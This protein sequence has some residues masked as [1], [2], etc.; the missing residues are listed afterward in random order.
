MPSFHPEILRRI[1]FSAHDV[2]TLRQLGEYRGKQE[3]F[4]RQRP[5]VLETLR[6]AAVVESTESSN[7]LEGIE[8]PK[9]STPSST[10]ST[11][12]AAPTR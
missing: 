11:P 5:E 1:S 3:L 6:T 2:A 7:R 4:A 10:G 8:A 12:T 9:D